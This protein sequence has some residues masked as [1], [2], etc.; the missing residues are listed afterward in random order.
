MGL[1]WIGLGAVLLWMGWDAIGTLRTKRLSSREVAERVYGAGAPE[2][3]EHVELRVRT[4]W[5][6][7]GSSLASLMALA[8]CVCGLACVI[9]GVALILE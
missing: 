6:I 9:G 8:F 5:L 1:I 2:L 7:Q 3:P 4:S